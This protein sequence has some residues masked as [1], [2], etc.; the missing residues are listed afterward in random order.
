MGSLAMSTYLLPAAISVALLIYHL[1]SGGPEVV[2]PLLASQELPPDV[3]HTLY[4]CW[5]VVTIVLATFVAAY[6]LA[7]FDLAFRSYAF[8]A[9]VIAGV[10]A[11]WSFAVV[12][13]KR[14]KH[15]QMPQWIAFLVLALAGGWS[16]S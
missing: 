8:A 6:L 16:L 3:V 7:T 13:W 15:R 2:R 10:I 11:I 9:T 12:V 14:Q 4:I 1:F 5:H